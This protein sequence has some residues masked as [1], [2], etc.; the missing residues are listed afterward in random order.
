MPA[1]INLEWLNQN[2]LRAYPFKENSRRVPV[3]STGALLLDARIPD[4]LIVDFIITVPGSVTPRVYL[5][6]LVKLSNLATFVFTDDSGT[7]LTTIAVDLDAHIKYAG[8]ALTGVGVY[9]DVRGTLVLGDLERF[10]DELADGLYNFT[11]DSAEMESSTI[12]PAIR[13]VRSLQLSNQGSESAYIYGHVKLL[14]GNNVRLT[15]L[16]QYNAIRIDAIEGAGLNQ[17]CECEELGAQNIVRT[18]N[19]IPVEDLIIAGDGQCVDVSVS[20]NK[21]VISDKCSKPCCGCPELE[22]LTESLK[23]LESTVTNLQTYAHTLAERISNFVTN[24]VLTVGA[25]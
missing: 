20:G 21:I 5:R 18:V 16:A 4:S 3:A 22:F 1:T 9:D 12:R 10:D 14:A 17:E 15:Y 25:G 6:Q 23:I 13:G 24:F 2:S 7:D 8:Y 11:L 19:G